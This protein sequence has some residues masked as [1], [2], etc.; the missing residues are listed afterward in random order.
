MLA[1]QHPAWIAPEKSSPAKAGV[2]DSGIHSVMYPSIHP[3]VF[4][5]LTVAKAIKIRNLRTSVV[6]H[7]I[8]IHL[9]TQGAWVWSLVW[10][11]PVHGGATKPVRHNYWACALAPVSRHCWNPCA[12]EP[13]LRNKRRHHGAKPMHRKEE[14]SPLATTRE[15]PRTTR[16]TQ[17]RQIENKNK[18]INKIL[19]LSLKKN[20]IM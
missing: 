15:S 17:R 7:W 2:M 4:F 18:W 16:K 19:R 13:V 12:L 3:L 10:E 5:F 1:E 14:S 11:D 20:L 6:V 9:P 8:R